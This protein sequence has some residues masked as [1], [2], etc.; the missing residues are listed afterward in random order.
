MY[1]NKIA[2]RDI[3]LENLMVDAHVRGRKRRKK[4]KDQEKDQKEEEET[5][6]IIEDDDAHFCVFFF[7]SF[8]GYLRLVDF[9]FAK[10][11]RLGEKTFTFC[12]TPSYL[13]PEIIT[14]QGHGLEVDLWS[15][16]ILAFEL[17]FGDVPFDADD[18]NE[19]FLAIVKAQVRYPS[20]H[21]LSK[22][23]VDFCRRLLIK[24]PNKRLGGGKAG[25][26]MLK[27][28]NFFKGFDWIGLERKSY[29]DVPLTPAI[30]EETDV[31]N[32]CEVTQEEITTVMEADEV[33]EDRIFNAIL[34]KE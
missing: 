32:F 10:E 22:E 11:L 1:D 3:K 13:A 8:Q 16:G 14:S 19:L 30:E 27:K 28:H 2:H 18:E 20:Q 31:S 4:K 24:D 12:G 26:H 7:L 29:K 15:T 9:G 17:L 21:D 6:P 5:K 23:G 34:D 25:A 33:P